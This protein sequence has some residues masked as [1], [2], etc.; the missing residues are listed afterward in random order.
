MP[1]RGVEGQTFLIDFDGPTE[2][3]G[4]V[5]PSKKAVTTDGVGGD[6]RGLRTKCCTLISCPDY[7]ALPSS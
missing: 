5:P 4:H 6:R 3:F 7:L 2:D 1:G